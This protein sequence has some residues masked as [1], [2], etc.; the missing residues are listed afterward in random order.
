MKAPDHPTAPEENLA[1]RPLRILH[2]EDD[3]RDR[4]LVSACLLAHGF[5]FHTTHAKDRSEFEAALA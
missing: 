3:V 5:R 4:E 1:Q 2:L